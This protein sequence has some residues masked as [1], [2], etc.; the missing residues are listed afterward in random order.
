MTAGFLARGF[1]ERPGAHGI[2]LANQHGV[3]HVS[4]QVSAR[5]C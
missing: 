3:G 2:G 5:A 4:E 1:R